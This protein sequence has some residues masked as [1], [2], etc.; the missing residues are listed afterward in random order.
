MAPRNFD[1]TN[2]LGMIIAFACGMLAPPM[3]GVEPGSRADRER[4]NY[5]IT[6]ADRERL[7]AAEI[8]RARRQ[9]RNQ[10]IV[11]FAEMRA[12]A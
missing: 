8:K 10:K 3:S 4:H 1:I 9:L 6:A 11:C 12:A 2:N 7:R 5:K